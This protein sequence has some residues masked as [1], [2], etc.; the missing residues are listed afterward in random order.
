MTTKGSAHRAQAFL[1]SGYSTPAV[2]FGSLHFLRASPGDLFQRLAPRLI[3]A[4]RSMPSA[5]QL[6]LRMSRR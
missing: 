4:L 1:P 5:F 3:R 6:D 2:R